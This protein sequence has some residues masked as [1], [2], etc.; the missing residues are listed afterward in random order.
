LNLSYR[1]N[2]VTRITD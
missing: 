2:S 1:Q